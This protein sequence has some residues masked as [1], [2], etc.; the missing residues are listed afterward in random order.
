M[1]ENSNTFTKISRD[2]TVV[3]IEIFCKDAK[4][5]EDTVRNLKAIL[6]EGREIRIKLPNASI[7][8]PPE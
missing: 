4:A 8:E 1:S 6:A 5:A 7:D 3:L 2:A